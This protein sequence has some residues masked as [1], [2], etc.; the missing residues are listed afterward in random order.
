MAF[1]NPLVT[2]TIPEGA[3]DSD[4]RLVITSN[5]ADMPPDL[6]AAGI[7]SVIIFFY[8]WGDYIYLGILPSV[9]TI[10]QLILG[11]YD[12]TG[13]TLYQLQQWGGS[14]ISDAGMTLGIM[15]D[16]INGNLNY[17]LTAN[18]SDMYEANAGVGLVGGTHI[19]ADRSI[20][21]KFTVEPADLADPNLP[22]TDTVFSTGD[23]GRGNIFAYNSVLDYQTAS[24][25]LSSTT[26]S[27]FLDANGENIRIES[28]PMYP[29][30]VYKVRLKAHLYAPDA[31]PYR[32]TYYIRDS[33]DATDRAV[34]AYYAAVSNGWLPV[35]VYLLYG[36]YTDTTVYPDISLRGSTGTAGRRLALLGQADTAGW[37]FYVE[38]AGHI[39]DY[40]DS[41][42]D[43]QFT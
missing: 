6:Q 9:G 15:D 17:D 7:S 5:P 3:G 20:L 10:A 41:M 43:V 34:A 28:C 4:Y 22:A 35:N 14:N 12:A 40:A 2:L 42:I 25:F 29:N 37:L 30:R 26:I 18:N 24:G 21:G 33:I 39:F 11:W 32:T 1:K 31:V 19:T 16:T 23:V 8:P 27:Q 13:A 38:D 36:N